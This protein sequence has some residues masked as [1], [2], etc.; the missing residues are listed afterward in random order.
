MQTSKNLQR[1]LQKRP[2]NLQADDSLI[3]LTILSSVCAK[4]CADWQ[5]TLFKKK[6]H[7]LFNISIAKMFPGP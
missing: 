6:V 3:V 1:H 5:V 7:D 2:L 4:I